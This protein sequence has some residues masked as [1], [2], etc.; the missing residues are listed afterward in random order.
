MQGY[1]SEIKLYLRNEQMFLLYISRAASKSAQSDKGLCDDSIYVFYTNQRF[2]VKPISAL[3]VDIGTCSHYVSRLYEIKREN[4]LFALR[5][6]VV[7]YDSDSGYVL[8]KPLLQFFS[9]VLKL[10]RR[11]LHSLRM[12]MGSSYYT[13]ETCL[14]NFD[15]IKTHFYI[16]N[17]G[18]TGVNI[19]FFFS[20]RGGSNDFPQSMF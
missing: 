5:G 11:S 12:C 9:I 19:I 4:M 15:P 18:F 3:A 14:Y 2:S 16:V 6:C 8:R 1:P 13:T 10:C 20:R 17:L 7:S